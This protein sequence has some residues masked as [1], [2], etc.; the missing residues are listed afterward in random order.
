MTNHVSHSE[1]QAAGAPPARDTEHAP[2]FFLLRA[3]LYPN[4][5]AW[6]VFL[7]ALDV[8]LT[9][10][11]LYAGGSE[12][13]RLA[14]GIIERWG[15]PGLVVYKFVIVGFVLCTINIIGRLRPRAGRKL[16]EWAVALT[17]IPV[18][19]APLQLLVMAYG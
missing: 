2:R 12:L 6:F 10:C 1:K 8:M 7:S 18:V 5:C 14:D 9:W 3:T 15:M 19:L 11:V 17:C 16:A 13:N 4:L